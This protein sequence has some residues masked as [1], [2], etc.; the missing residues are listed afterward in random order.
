M[1]STLREIDSFKIFFP[2]SLCI[3][4]AQCTNEST[5]ITYKKMLL[6]LI[7]TKEMVLLG[8]MFVMCY[9]RLP[10][11]SDYW[12]SNHSMGHQFIKNAISRNRLQFLMSKLYFNHPEKPDNATKLYYVE[13]LKQTFSN[14][15]TASSH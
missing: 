5:C 1:P 13:E 3:F 10:I 4:I 2:K 14:A 7:L 12:S 9:N 15:M 11:L 6:F 8:V